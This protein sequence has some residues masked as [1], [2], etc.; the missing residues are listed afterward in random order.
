METK[1]IRSI[2]LNM[3]ERKNTIKTSKKSNLTYSH[4]YKVLDDLE[5]LGL[6]ISIRNGRERLVE[7]TDKGKEAKECILNLKK[8]GL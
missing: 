5:N 2:L 3:N 7:L 6:I 4:T 8:L 1:S